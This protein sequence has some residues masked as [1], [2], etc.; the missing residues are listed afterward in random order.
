LV[1][2]TI[3]V[4]LL[5]VVEGR[6]GLIGVAHANLSKNGCT[7]LVPRKLENLVVD[8]KADVAQICVSSLQIEV[9]CFQ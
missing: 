7:N 5:D 4:T 6:L 8:L 9:R 3:D 1:A 2:I